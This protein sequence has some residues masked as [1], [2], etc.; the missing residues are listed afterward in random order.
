MIFNRKCSIVSHSVRLYNKGHGA[1]SLQNSLMCCINFSATYPSTQNSRFLSFSQCYCIVHGVMS[2][3]NLFMDCNI[4]PFTYPSTRNSLFKF[5]LILALFN[6]VDVEQL[7]VFSIH[8][9]LAPSGS[10]YT[11]NVPA[12]FVD[13]FQYFPIM[14]PSTHHSLSPLPSH[15]SH[16]KL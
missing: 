1:M 2:L 16:F 3:P 13:A 7:L 15:S 4:F 5:T 6:I 11:G 14:Y 10:L 12:K 9:F 8:S